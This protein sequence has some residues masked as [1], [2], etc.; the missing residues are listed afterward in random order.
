MRPSG[1]LMERLAAADPLAGAEDLGPGEQSEADALLAQLVATPAE[2][3]A[4]PARVRRWALVAAGALC[5]VAAAFAV[6]NLLDSDTRG[7]GVVERAVAAV[8]QGGSVY[9]VMERMHA[10]PLGIRGAKGGT[11][12]FESWHTTGG[13]AHRKAFEPSG[14]HRGR[15]VEEWAGRR[16]PGRRGGPFLRW[17]V[18]TNTI[19]PGGFAIGRGTRGAP[20][21]DPFGDPGVQ[22]RA[23]QQEGRLRLDGTTKVG[24]RTAYRLVSGT[25]PGMTK[26]EKQSVV[27]FVDSETYLPLAQRNSIRHGSGRGFD[28]FI[29]YLAYERLPLNS[30]TR[31]ELDLDPHPG[32]KCSPSNDVLKGRRAQIGFP[33]PCKR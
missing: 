31:K 14:G 4:P 21:L 15:L 26:R 5:S 12:Y 9:H 16:L 20:A 8:S 33:N 7:P 29:R 18:Y 2:R 1:D 3:G 25:V 10:T 11:F 24:D 6:V 22:L 23:L 30:S 27:F 19:S 17:D 13:R 32:A 28:W